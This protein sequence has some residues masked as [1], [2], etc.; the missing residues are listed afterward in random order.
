MNKA[1]PECHTLCYSDTNNV[2]QLLHQLSRQQELK[3]FVEKTK[4][5]QEG[6]RS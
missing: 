2:L 4:H 6:K 1:N 3:T 5:Y